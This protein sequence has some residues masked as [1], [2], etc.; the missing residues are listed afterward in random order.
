VNA[1]AS[2]RRLKGPGRPLVDADI[3]VS[4]A[5]RANPGAKGAATVTIAGRLPTALRR[6]LSIGE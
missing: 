2:V 4:H 6:D 3:H 5:P 1:D